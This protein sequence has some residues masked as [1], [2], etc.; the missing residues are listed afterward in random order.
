MDWSYDGARGHHVGPDGAVLAYRS[1][2]RYPR[3]SDLAVLQEDFADPTVVEVDGTFYMYGTATTRL[4]RT[5]SAGG[6]EGPFVASGERVSDGFTVVPVRAQVARSRDLHAWELLPFDALAA[7]PQWLPSGNVAVSVWA[8]HPVLS[9]SGTALLYYSL[10]LTR[11]RDPARRLAGSVTSHVSVATADRP[12]GPFLDRTAA[13]LLSG[14][15][16]RCIDPFVHLGDDGWALVVGSD[17]ADITEHALDDTGTRVRVPSGPGRRLLAPRA[18][19][20]YH[21]V[22][23]APYLAGD[24]LLTSGADCFAND[25]PR[26]WAF[27]DEPGAEY[28]WYRYGGYAVLQALPG[29]AGFASRTGPD[30][31]LDDVVLE[32]NEDVKNPGNACVVETGGRTYLVGHLIDRDDQYLGRTAAERR[33][34]VNRRLPFVVEAFRRADGSLE[35][36]GGQFHRDHRGPEHAVRHFR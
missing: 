4:A 27:P 2:G 9:P 34:K 31:V 13:P 19:D 33:A 23:E 3:A 8:S 26:E 5:R 24:L 36:P 32:G 22:Q 15:G 18:G 20:V 12:E 29:D 6:S 7:L 16:Y 30:G 21:R 1:G 25:K 35:V 10:V 17:G 28:D 14:P 11:Y